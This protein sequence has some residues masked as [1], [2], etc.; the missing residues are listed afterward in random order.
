MPQQQQY[1]SIQ[2]DR[3]SQDQKRAVV[4]LCGDQVTGNVT[5][6]QDCKDGPVRII[7]TVYGLQDGDFGFHVHE[8]GDITG[9]CISAG[10][11]YN[12]ENVIQYTN[13]PMY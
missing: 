7:G 2:Q 3:C 9:G 13:F 1:Q 11:H 10:L 4:K 8:K 5:F 6:I 12:P